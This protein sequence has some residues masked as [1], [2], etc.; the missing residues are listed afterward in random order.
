MISEAPT[1][2]PPQQHTGSAKRGTTFP[3]PQR[4]EYGAGGHLPGKAPWRFSIKANSVSW[5][6]MLKISSSGVV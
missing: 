1:P 2:P 5:K 3:F 4:G 6:E